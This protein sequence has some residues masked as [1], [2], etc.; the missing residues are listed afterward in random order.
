LLDHLY[1]ELFRHEVM[2]LSA[3]CLAGE[4][5]GAELDVYPQALRLHG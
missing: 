4:A 2:L 5:A 1:A 3:R